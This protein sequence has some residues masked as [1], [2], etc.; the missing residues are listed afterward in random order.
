MSIIA[1]AIE[2]FVIIAYCLTL[3][4]GGQNAWILSKDVVLAALKLHSK[5]PH[6]LGSGPG[7][8]NESF[9]KGEEI[10]LFCDLV[11]WL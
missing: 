5:A 11:G 7:F 8:S 4:H 9:V 2:E 6:Y 1:R 3:L 10:C